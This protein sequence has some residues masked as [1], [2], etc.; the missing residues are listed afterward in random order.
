TGGQHCVVRRAP[1]ERGSLPPLVE[2]PFTQEVFGQGP[3]VY[4][5]QPPPIQPHPIPCEEHSH[6]R[7]VACGDPSDERLIGRTFASRCPLKRCGGR[8][9]TDANRSHRRHPLYTLVSHN[10]STAED[11]VA[12]PLSITSMSGC[13][14]SF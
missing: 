3:V 13:C 2:K 7:L 6:S 14:P 8:L 9:S 11:E 10:R 5:A 12:I 4:E 1:L